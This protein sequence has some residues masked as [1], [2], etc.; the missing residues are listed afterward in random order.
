MAGILFVGAKAKGYFIEE[1]VA[2]KHSEGWTIDYIEVLSGLERN[3][4]KIL[5]KSQKGYDYIVYDAVEL[6]DDADVIAET[7]RH[8]ERSNGIKPIVMVS[9]INERN[10]LTAACIERGITNFINAGAA[11]TSDLKREFIRNVTGYY[12]GNGRQDVVETVKA[13]DKRKDIFKRVN[14]IGV[15]GS[16]RRIGT[17]T[18]AIQIVKYLSAMGYR[19]CLVELNAIR[20]ENR[21]LSRH[22]R[23]TLSFVEKT[24]LLMDISNDDRE[25]GFI[26]Y[27]GVDM[28]YK[29]DRISEILSDGYDYVVYDYGYYQDAEFNKTSFLKDDIQVFCVCAN[30]AEADYAFDIAENVSYR[31]AKLLFS[32]SKEGDREEIKN[33]FAAYEVDTDRMFFSDYT[34][35]PY[36]LTN[37]QLYSSMIPLE[38][39]MNETEKTEK[40]TKRGFW[41]RKKNR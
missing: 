3:I 7:I 17:T 34:P 22:E 6:A 31:N 37:M 20:Y 29:Q 9:T 5:I 10:T 1:I 13:I 8:I 27:E 11:T 33:L 16:C 35:D 24:R 19:A 18:Q 2:S 12:D 28:F 40:K 25:R 38:K 41:G 36:M 14:T 39:R 15:A 32:F 23:E 30:A 21:K 4:D 26:R